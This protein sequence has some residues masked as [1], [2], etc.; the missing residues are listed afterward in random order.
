M[1]ALTTLRA[2]RFVNGV[3]DEQAAQIRIQLARKA[4]QARIDRIQGAFTTLRTESLREADIVQGLHAM[5]AGLGNA[6]YVGSDERS[7][8]EL[9][10][11]TA[12]EI[13]FRDQL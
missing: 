9:L 6:A 10:D 5:S 1:S 11:V 4:T 7:T 12:D 2:P 8:I 13:Q 3:Y